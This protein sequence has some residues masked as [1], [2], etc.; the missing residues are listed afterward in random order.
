[1]SV[2]QSVLEGAQFCKINQMGSVK[3][4]IAI[5]LAISN[6]VDMT[7]TGDMTL[8]IP[9]LLNGPATPTSGLFMVTVRQDGVGGHAI[10]LSNVYTPSIISFSGI[11][12][13]VN[14]LLMQVS[15]DLSV[16]V[17][18]FTSSTS[19]GFGTAVLTEEFQTAG[20]T[21]PSGVVYPAGGPYPLAN[22]PKLIADVFGDGLR[23][24]FSGFSIASNLLT[25]QNSRT[26]FQT[27][28]CTYS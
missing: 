10:S 12:N 17:L 1:M 19:A 11:P 22:F 27:V 20:G 18:A 25:V 13:A 21:T 5:D 14:V 2:G 7:A 26:Y 15:P 8:I 3:G 23:Q 6:I 9:S 4:L 16:K 24:P 28:A